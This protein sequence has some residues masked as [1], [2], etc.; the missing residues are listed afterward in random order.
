MATNNFKAFAL[1]PNAN[2]MSQADWEALPALLSGFTA[3]KASS[4]QVN[5]AIRQATTIAAL[6]GQFIANSGVDALDNADVNGLVT[7]FT[8]ALTTN[9]GLG[10]ASKRNVGTGENQIPDMS[11]FASGSG[12]QK[13]PGGYILQWGSANAGNSSSTGISNTFPIPFP[14][15]IVIITTGQ[16]DPSYTSTQQPAAVGI[17]S[18][19]LT[20]FIAKSAAANTDAFNYLAIG[21]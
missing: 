18:P 4:A 14:S 10:T 20:G 21:Y 15:G 16:I 1:D 9:L 3:G 19:T 13:L 12:Y 2:V 8:N 6:V 11:A 17:S 7:K 5:K